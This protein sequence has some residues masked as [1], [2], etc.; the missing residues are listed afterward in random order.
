MEA[1]KALNLGAVDRNHHCLPNRLA[2]RERD[3]M[4]A[5]RGGERL[6]DKRTAFEANKD[7]LI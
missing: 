6:M 5:L 3:D 2:H 1:H 7:R 4:A